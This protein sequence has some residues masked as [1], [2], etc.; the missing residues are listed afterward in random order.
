MNR[1]VINILLSVVGILNTHMS[2]SV[3]VIP[4]LQRISLCIIF[5]PVLPV[6]AS[7]MIRLAC[8]FVCRRCVSQSSLSVS[9]VVCVARCRD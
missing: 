4:D 8:L 9:V 5:Q 2:H 7:Q 1:A 3:S 6:P